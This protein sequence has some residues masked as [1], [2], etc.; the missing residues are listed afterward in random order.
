MKRICVTGGAGFIGSNLV[1]RLLGEGYAVTVIDDFSSGK[2]SNLAG[3]DIKLIEGSINCIELLD[4]ALNECDLIIHLAAM[5]SVNESI[6]N[7]EKTYNTNVKATFNL[8][9]MAA[10]LGIKRIVY[11]SSAAVYGNVETIPFKESADTKTISPYGTS[12]YMNELM[13]ADFNSS[14]ETEFIGLRFMNVYGPGQ[15]PSSSYSGVISKF[16]SNVL[17]GMSH[18][19]FGDGGQTRDFVFV[20]DILQGIIK[21]AFTDFQLCKKLPVFNIGTGNSTSITQL[22]E[23]LDKIVL[24]DTSINY[25][26]VRQGDIEHS[27]ADISYAARLLQF[28]PQYSLFDGLS[29]TVDWYKA[30]GK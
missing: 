5:V 11:A 18:T 30:D 19:I 28:E 9:N 3:L 22:A 2:R 24:K 15:D 1:K 20:E 27:V 10:K 12:K 29:R 21:A 16:C 14:Y 26:E 6:S 8:F 4:E 17:N 23:T 13:A 7:I 25:G